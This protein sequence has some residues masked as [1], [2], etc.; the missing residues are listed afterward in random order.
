VTINGTLESPIYVAGHQGLIG[1]AIVRRLKEAGHNDLL[2]RT[3]AALDLEDRVTVEA[4]FDAERPKT[5]FLAAGRTGGI[6]ENRTHPVGLVETNLAIQLNVMSAASRTGVSTLV[7]F[8]ASCMYPREC[9]QPMREDMLLTG[10]PEPTSLPYA[11]VK[12][13]GVQHCLALNKEAGTSRFLP[14]IPNSTY[15]PDDNFDPDT[16]HVVAALLRRFHMA[17]E[18][19][20]NSV[21]LWGSGSP[22]REFVFADDVADACF[23]LALHGVSEDAMPINIGVGEEVSIQ[24]L[25]ERTAAVTGY[26]GAIEWDRSKPDGSPRKLLDTSRLRASGWRPRFTLDEGLRLTYGWMLENRKQARLD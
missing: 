24:S 20:D 12:L 8:G 25:A 9:P 15:G 11:M 17:R 2:L 4:F 19:G 23:H 21:M 18:R 22:R 5:V 16:S 7:F 14:V 13:A 26:R 1:S 6:E 10:I 3:H